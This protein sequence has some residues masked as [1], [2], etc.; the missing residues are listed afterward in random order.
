[1]TIHAPINVRQRIKSI[2]GRRPQIRPGRA[3]E[4]SRMLESKPGVVVYSEWGS[5]GMLGFKRG[6]VPQYVYLGGKD[7]REESEKIH[8]GRPE[9]FKFVDSVL[10]EFH[11][12]YLHCVGS[13]DY[14]HW[15]EDEA[16]LN[17]D[18]YAR[19]REME[20]RLIEEHNPPRNNRRGGGGRE[21]QWVRHWLSKLG[22][23][24]MRQFEGVR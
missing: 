9:K 4:D 5:Q 18:G 21:P 10:V 14:N 3:V 23:T 7:V 2:P 12:Y 22:F 24:S 8:Q 13:S 20:D 6:F 19:V 16:L 15:T 1:M 17:L 11:P